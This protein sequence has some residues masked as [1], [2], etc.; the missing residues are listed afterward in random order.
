MLQDT[1]NHSGMG[2]ELRRE[3]KEE[4][5]ERERVR[6]KRENERVRRE[7]EREQFSGH[8]NSIVNQIWE[9]ERGE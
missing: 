3:K 6:D 7:R 4:K 1:S 5:G 2:T 9:R 8:E